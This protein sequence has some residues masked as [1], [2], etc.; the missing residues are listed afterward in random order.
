MAAKRRKKHKAMHLY[1]FD[2][3]PFWRE[4][5]G[6]NSSCYLSILRPLRLFAAISTADSRFK[7]PDLTSIEIA[8]RSDGSG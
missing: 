3:S 2:A 4:V 6:S 7:Q 5:T 1:N 8:W